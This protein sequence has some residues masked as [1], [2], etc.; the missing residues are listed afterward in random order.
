MS[1]FDPYATLEVDSSASQE[2]VSA[3]YR[4]LARRFHPDV[5]H[6]PEAAA[7][8]VAINAAWELLRNPTVRAT[9]DRQHARTTGAA[10]PGAG[11]PSAPSTHSYTAGGHRWQTGAAPGTGAAG[12]APGRPSGSVL[13]FG[14]HVGWSI[15]EIARVDPGYLTWL[16]SKPEGRPYLAEIDATMRR[17]GLRQAAPEAPARRGRF[18]RG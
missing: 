6:G 5:A 1:E 4:A 3:A 18:G 14:R 10:E 17:I 11:A 2:V 13:G 9:W 12:P 8:M 16:E 15:G 7:H